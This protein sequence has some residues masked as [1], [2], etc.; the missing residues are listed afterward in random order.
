VNVPSIEHH[1]GNPEQVSQ[2]VSQKPR[3]L[4]SKV[5]IEHQFMDVQSREI[6]F[7]N[8]KNKNFYKLND[9]TFKSD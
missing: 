1:E 7:H 5:G 3:T 9:Q 6:S 8:E 2:L 4:L